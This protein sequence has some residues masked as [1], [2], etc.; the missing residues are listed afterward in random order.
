MLSVNIHEINENGRTAF[1]LACRRG[2]SDVVKIFLENASTLSFDLNKKDTEGWTG[3]IWACQEGNSNVVKLLME[4]AS[5]LN[6][7]LNRQ[8]TVGN[9]TKVIQLWCRSGIK[10]TMKL[11]KLVEGSK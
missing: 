6:I 3:F 4:N 1:H 8:I 9:V 5:A 10:E 2:N 11:R 7:D